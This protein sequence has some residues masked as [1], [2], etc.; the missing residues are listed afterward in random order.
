MPTNSFSHTKPTINKRMNILFLSVFPV[1]NIDDR[2]LYADLLRKFR[3]KGHKVYIVTPSERRNND[4]TSLLK[5]Q[6]A[7]LL[8]I[9]TPNLQKTNFFEKGLGFILLPFLFKKQIRSFF[10]D[11]KFDLILYATPP[12]T[13]TSV[14]RYFKRKHG[15]K[16]YL[17]LKDIFP[18]NAV[19]LGF[20]SPKNPIYWYFRN[21]EKNLYKYSDVIGCMSPANV[22]Y[23]KTQN[24][25][26]QNKPIEVCP[27]SIEPQDDFVS[28]SERMEIRKKY[29]INPESVFFL[30]GGN[31]GKPQGLDFLLNVIENTQDL[32][33]VF[34]LIIGSGTE[35]PKLNSWFNQTKPQNALL[36]ESVPKADFDLLVQSCDVGMIFLD[37]RFTIPNF[38]SRLL[39]Y[40]E[41][42]IPVIAATDKSTDLGTIMMGNGFGLWSESGDLDAFKENIKYLVS[43]T[44]R[45][46]IMGQKGRSYLEKNYHVSNAY[47]IIMKHFSH[48]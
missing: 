44:E 23:L 24:P 7:E 4:K 5:Q 11:V 8:K 20:L 40:L 30:Y 10:P 1:H 22:L 16:S 26:L 17:L 33:N 36:L 9:K 47:S 37:R 35:Y 13:F 21:K 48:V 12:I 41:Y 15:A 39:S 45:L 28:Y 38:P 2:N 34:F 42:S 29:G 14:I 25:S 27:N 32:E 46:K 43:D 6:G 19:D 18:Q 31:L 3:D